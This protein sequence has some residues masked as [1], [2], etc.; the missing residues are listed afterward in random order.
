MLFG[1]SPMKSGVRVGFWLVEKN[2]F[3][4]AMFAFFLCFF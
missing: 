4:L 3:C 2:T 1:V